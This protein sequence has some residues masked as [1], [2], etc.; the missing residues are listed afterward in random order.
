MS[1]AYVFPGQGAQQV[2]MGKDIAS[3]PAARAVFE[4]AD[5]VLGFPLS[6]LMFEGPKEQLDDTFN[7]QPALFT[8]GAALIELLPNRSPAFVAGHSLGEYTAL[9][10]AGVF[11][12]ADGLRLVRERGRLM[13]SAGE[14]DPGSMAAL[15]GLDDA[16][17]QAICAASGAVQVAN[18]NSPG[19]VV[20]SGKRDAVASAMQSARTHKA[21]LVTALDV[22]IASH[23]ALMQPV[24]D[25][26]ARAVRDTPM[27]EPQI[28]VVGNV[29]A[30]PLLDIDQVRDELIR[31]PVSSVQWTQSV[32]YMA[33]RGAD[34]FV[35]I[36]PGKVLTGLIKRIA[37]DAKLCN[38]SDADSLKRFVSE[39]P[40]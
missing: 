30:R 12:F 19:Q 29:S 15:I 26:F 23:S 13:K 8:M 21:R 28:T 1:I 34:T 33:E 20:I 25:P 17:V 31:Q 27:R 40:A 9:Y 6:A 4:E 18:Y 11:S 14:R 22:S 24:V 32:A 5:A 3:L 38:L 35:E 10:A 39:E 2:G 36:G 16:T 7:T 37:K